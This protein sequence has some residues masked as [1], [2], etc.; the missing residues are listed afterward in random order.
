MCGIFPFLLL[1]CLSHGFQGNS[2]SSRT[3]MH[4]CGGSEADEKP[5]LLYDSRFTLSL[6]RIKA[7]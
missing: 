5:L 4:G 2:I 3:D 6:A 7:N 1:K